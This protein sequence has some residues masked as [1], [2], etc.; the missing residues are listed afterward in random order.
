MAVDDKTGGTSRTAPTGDA[1]V[2]VD[3]GKQKRKQVRELR[4]GCGKLLDEVR[5]TIGELQRAGRVSSSAQPVVVVVVQ[6]PK[7]KKFGKFPMMFR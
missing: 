1:P 6:K 5:A 3:L 2:I 7:A 4:E